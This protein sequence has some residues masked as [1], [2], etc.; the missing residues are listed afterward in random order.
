MGLR[1]PMPER[2]VQRTP[3][4][5]PT[6]ATL[7]R[8]P[9][10]AALGALWPN[11]TPT[12]CQGC[13]MRTVM[14]SCCQ[15]PRRRSLS[16]HGPC[17]GHVAAAVASC[18]QAPPRYPFPLMYSYLQPRVNAAGSTGLNCSL[19]LA[20]ASEPPAERYMCGARVGDLPYGQFSSV[21]SRWHHVQLANR[22]QHSP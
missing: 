2:C 14:L 13:A 17:L 15:D 9:G 4:E 5:S 8:P 19:Q 12:V 10:H 6:Q 1:Y 21:G 18:V 16:S 11:G 22:R 7:L 3:P 20:T